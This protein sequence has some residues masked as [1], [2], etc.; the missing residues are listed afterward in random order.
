MIQNYDHAVKAADGP[1]GQK[2]WGDMPKEVGAPSIDP[3]F[4]FRHIYNTKMPINSQPTCQDE[5]PRAKKRGY[6]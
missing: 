4:S 5:I 2:I 1:I 3:L 6:D